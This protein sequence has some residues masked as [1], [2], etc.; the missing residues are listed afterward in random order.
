MEFGS[1]LERV[2]PAL[3]GG[4]TLMIMGIYSYLTASTEEKDR[5]FRYSNKFS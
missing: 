4:Q 5:T 3:F 2:L 1:I